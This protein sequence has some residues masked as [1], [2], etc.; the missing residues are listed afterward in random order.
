MLIRILQSVATAEN[1]AA[2]IIFPTAFNTGMEVN[3]DSKL[4]SSWVERG[5]AEVVER[6]QGVRVET[7]MLAVPEKAMM[8]RPAPKKKLKV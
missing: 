3:V 7:A 6:P 2:G 4:G 1:P 8:R 5:I